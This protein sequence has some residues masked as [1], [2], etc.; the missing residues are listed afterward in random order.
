MSSSTNP[1][2]NL[3]TLNDLQPNLTQMKEEGHTN[4]ELLDWLA[5]EGFIISDSTLRRRLRA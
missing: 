5:R 3:R 1:N 4:E 2:P